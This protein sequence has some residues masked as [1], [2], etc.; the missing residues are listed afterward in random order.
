MRGIPPLHREQLGAKGGLQVRFPW[1]L[2]FTKAMRLEDH[3]RSVD[4]ACAEIRKRGEA[5]MRYLDA[6]DELVLAAADEV[7]DQWDKGAVDT[8]RWTAVLG[9][10]TKASFL[11]RNARTG[12][13][14]IME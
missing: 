9:I 10:L 7:A 3:R 2:F 8:E 1:P 12:S 14:P 13:H 4:L 6:Y 11:R 5:T